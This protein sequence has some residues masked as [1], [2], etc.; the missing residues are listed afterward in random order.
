MLSKQINHKASRKLLM[1]T[2]ADSTSAGRL[3]FEISDVVLFAARNSRVTGIQRVQLNLIRLLASKHDIR[4]VFL[5]PRYN[6]MCEFDPH[7]LIA[8]AEFESEG[9]LLQ[10][11]IL[12]GWE[13]FPS[14]YRVKEYL[15]G[16]AG[17]KLLRNCKKVDLY[18]SA[19]MFPARFAKTGLRRMREMRGNVGK[20]RVCKNPELAAGDVLVFL[21]A[22]WSL[23]AVIEF[24]RRHAAEGG[25]VVQ[26]V[27]DLI[28]ALYPQYCTEGVTRDFNQWLGLVR[29]HVSRFMCISRCTA[30]DLRTA[31]HIEDTASVAVVPLAHELDGFARNSKQPLAL[32]AALDSAQREF[33]LCAGTIEIRKNGVALLR[34]WVKLY[35]EIGD[36]LPLLV[37]A[38]K[39]GWMI[40]EFD[41][42]M[43]E[44]PVLSRWVK[45]VESPSDSELAALYQHCLFTVY[46]SLYEGWGL[47]IG[48]STW[49][50][51]YCV[52]SACSSMPEVCG[53]LVDYI[54]PNSLES[55]TGALRR[56]IVDREYLLGCEA[57][58]RAAPLRTWED[59][60]NHMFDLL[61]SGSGWD[62]SG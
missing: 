23:P 31:L 58:I 50:G 14:K 2:M 22:N 57:K 1:S 33:V 4:C 37:F 61:Q 19:L 38:G 53:D 27:Y 44:E 39:R 18:L 49:F 43:T 32:P 8:S 25:G 17:N 11:G 13:G 21:G 16:Y 3:Y 48:E 51:K 35:A 12:R 47:P 6:L 24:G 54:D 29:E 7:E 26:L 62:Q 9:M 36:Q 28:P 30:N 55:L 40:E 42:V 56:A 5:H 52:T 59:V 60:A 34:G 15:R 45:I 46:P 41:K 20:I 10:L